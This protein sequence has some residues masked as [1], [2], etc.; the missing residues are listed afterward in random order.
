MFVHVHVLQ[1]SRF[2]AIVVSFSCEGIFDE[3]IERS[4]TPV[5]AEIKSVGGSPLRQYNKVA[6]SFHSCHDCTSEVRHFFAKNFIT[7]SMV[8]Q[9]LISWRKHPFDA[10]PLPSLPIY[11]FISII[12]KHCSGRIVKMF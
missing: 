5:A 3:G 9:N 7:N 12:I 10:L 8:G 1:T 4:A 11:I 2:A 6:K